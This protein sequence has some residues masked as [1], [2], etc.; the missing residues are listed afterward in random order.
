MVTEREVEQMKR[1]F[2]GGGVIIAGVMALAALIA[3]VLGQTWALWPFI[4]LLI[5][6]IMFAV[7]IIRRRRSSGGRSVR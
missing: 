4:P 5:I 2:V 1:G 6:E 3:V 7:A